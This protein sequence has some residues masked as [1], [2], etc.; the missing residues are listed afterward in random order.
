MRALRA[1]LSRFGG[2]FGEGRRERE[3]AAEMESHLQLRIEGNL[4]AGMN[5]QEARRHALL[6]LGG[7]L[8]YE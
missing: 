4:R 2:L 7:A 8:R 5:A 3:L 6:K 1:W